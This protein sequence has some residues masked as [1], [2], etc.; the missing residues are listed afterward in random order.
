MRKNELLRTVAFFAA[1]AVAPG[2]CAG[3]PHD[4]SPRCLGHC[5]LPLQAARMALAAAPLP[6]QRRWAFSY[7]AVLLVQTDITDHSRAPLLLLPKS[8]G[9]LGRSPAQKPPVRASELTRPCAGLALVVCRSFSSRLWL[10]RPARRPSETRLA[11]SR[12]RAVSPYRSLALFRSECRFHGTLLIGVVWRGC[13]G[14]DVLLVFSRPVKP[15]V[16]A[17]KKNLRLNPNW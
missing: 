8:A 17:S 2:V 7:I 4:G 13:N 14:L 9:C 3:S 12:S 11:T 1:R 16:T 15:V 10:V 5:Y 6:K